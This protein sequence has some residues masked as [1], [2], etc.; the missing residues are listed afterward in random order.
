[1][2]RS[3]KLVWGVGINDADYPVIESHRELNSEGEWYTVVTRTCPIYQAWK[4]ML[5]RCYSKKFLEKMPTYIGCSVSEEWL[6]FSNFKQ[7]METQDWQGKQL[8]KDILFKGNK[9]YS[10]DTCVFITHM[11][12]SFVTDSAKARGKYPIGVN[13]DKRSGRFYSSCGDPLGRNGCH[14]GTYDTPEEAYD[15]WRIVKLEYAK[16]V[17]GLQTDPRV[18][19]A[20]I[21]RY[22]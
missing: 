5:Q 17:A 19:E 18:A 12:N 6:T 20:L 22:S 11:T 3:R 21:A 15:A 2:S 14:I 16:D 7:W 13:L 9:V 8:D 4:G 10:K 1:M